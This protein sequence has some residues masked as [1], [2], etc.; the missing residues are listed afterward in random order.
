M[1]T[2]QVLYNAL[3]AQL[4]V[5]KVEAE[6][7]TDNIYNTATSEL[8]G[9]V[10]NYFTEK[11]KD[12]NSFNFNGSSIRLELG[13]SYYDRIEISVN[14]PYRERDKNEIKLDW[15]SGN[16]TSNKNDNGYQ[17]LN[18]LNN[19]YNNFEEITNKYLNEWWP[20]YL[21]VE[22]GND[23]AWKEH[24]D[25]KQALDNLSREIKQDAIIAMKQVGFE[26]KKFKDDTQLDWSYHNNE[27]TYA[28]VASSKHIKL[29]YG[30]SQYDTTYIDGFKVLGKK[31]NKYNIEVY[32]E[33]SPNKVY[34]VLEK[35]FESFIEDANRWENDEASKRSER[36]K[37][38]YAERTK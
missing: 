3:A 36:V 31:G 30:R 10:L 33:G 34:N 1:N 13:S 20:A 7:Y 15:N 17:Y 24:N 29:Q 25:L 9:N 21:S 35:K 23:D 18:L 27:R 2:K 8:K 11:I 4:E 5:K 12:F 19:V 28:I 22:K 14:N 26:I 37:R 6:K 16:V 32:R 38:D